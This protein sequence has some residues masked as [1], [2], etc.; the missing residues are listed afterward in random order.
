MNDGLQMQRV[1]PRKAPD[2]SRNPRWK[3]AQL[4]V[5]GWDAQK[6]GDAVKSL[7]SWYDGQGPVRDRLKPPESLFARARQAVAGYH[8]SSH[9]E[10]RFEVLDG[11]ANTS[12]VNANYIRGFDGIAKKY[13]ASMGYVVDPVVSRLCLAACRRA[14]SECCLLR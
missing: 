4:P 7:R 1:Q 10:S 14:C 2:E 11:D 13:I 5:H 3:A 6:V 9:L 8:D 12:Y